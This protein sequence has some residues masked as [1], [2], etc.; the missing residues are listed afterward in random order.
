AYSRMSPKLP[1]ITANYLLT[2]LK[3]HDFVVVRQSG[4]HVIL[5]H[6]NG[7]HVTVPVHQGRDLGKGLLRQIMR[8]ANLSV[9]DLTAGRKRS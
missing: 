3:R 9:D 5:E 8:D 6:P 7:T 1:A 4:S 2:V